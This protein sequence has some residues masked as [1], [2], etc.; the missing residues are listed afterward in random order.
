MRCRGLIGAPVDLVPGDHVCWAYE[1]DEELVSTIRSWAVDGV[2]KGERILYIAEQP[3]EVLKARLDV[4]EDLDRLID[5]RRVILGDPRTMYG[6]GPVD[7]LS[8]L[9]YYATATADALADG[10]AGLRVAAEVH[11]LSGT[12][13]V[14]AFV[15]WE[16]LADSFMNQSPMSALCA[17]DR[18]TVSDSAIAAV[19]AAHPTRHGSA[20]STAFVLHAHEDGLRLAG[21]VETFDRFRLESMLRNAAGDRESV[22]LHLEDLQHA[23]GGSTAVLHAFARRLAAAGGQ[24]VFKG[25]S[26]AFRDAWAALGFGSDD[27]VFA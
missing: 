23:S 24:L 10:C 17:F 18:R 2:A 12:A 6:D 13:A 11:E 4:L 1:S 22:V 15:A 19:A 7:H 25:A 26:D 27:V 21:E 5:E 16:Q 14:D 20:T 9:T 8:L 3:T